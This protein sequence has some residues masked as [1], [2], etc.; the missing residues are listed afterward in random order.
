MKCWNADQNVGYPDHDW[1]DA[2]D[3]HRYRDWANFPDAGKVDF[4]AGP[5]RVCVNCGMRA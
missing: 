5:L 1:A 2:Y 4:P 3:W